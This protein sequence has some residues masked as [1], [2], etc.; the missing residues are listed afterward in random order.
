MSCSQPG[1][2]DQQPC[3]VRLDGEGEELGATS[4]SLAVRKALGHR[5]EDVAGQVGCDCDRLRRLKP[6]L[7]LALVVGLQV[8]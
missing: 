5:V 4:D 7:D 2:G 8:V 6:L 1:G 3:L